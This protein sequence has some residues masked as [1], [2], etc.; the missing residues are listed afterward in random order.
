MIVITC[1]CV[2]FSHRTIAS[3]FISYAHSTKS[4]RESRT[5]LLKLDAYNTLTAVAVR[6]AHSLHTL[7]YCRLEDEYMVYALMLVLVF[8]DH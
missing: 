4:P 6:G 3:L 7:S 2:L 1:V 8:S 5:S